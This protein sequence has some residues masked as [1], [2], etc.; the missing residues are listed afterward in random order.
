MFNARSERILDDH[1]S[2]WYRLRSNRCLIPVSGTFEHRRIKGWK[3]KVPYFIWIKER[4]IIYIPGLYQIHKSVGPNGEA[5]FEKSFTMI[6]R[7]ANEVMKGIHND[8]ENKHRMPLFLTPELEQ[9]WLL[10][11]LTENDMKDIFNYQMPDEAM[12]YRTVYTLRGVTERPDGK[13]KYDFWKWPN[14][15]PLGNDNPPQA[16]LSLF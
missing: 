4:E 9:A 2:Y 13:R 1:E 10:P 5:I 14:L 6:T 7:G 15:P 12:D 16:Q 11:D 3:N 8:G